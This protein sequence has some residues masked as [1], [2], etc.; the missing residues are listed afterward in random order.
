MT[1]KPLKRRDDEIRM[2]VISKGQMI[3]FNDVIDNRAYATS[4][5]CISS[6]GVV[7]AIKSEEFIN[8]MQSSVTTW[9]KLLKLAE[10]KDKELDS[11]IWNATYNF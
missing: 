11:Q 1:L 9:R 6:Q 4:L 7:L 10:E 8:K 2:A 5:K 3:G